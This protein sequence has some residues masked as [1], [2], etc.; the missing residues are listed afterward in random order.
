[1]LKVLY[2]IAL[3]S[4]SP[5]SITHLTF[6]L[7][8]GDEGSVDSVYFVFS[9]QQADKAASEVEGKVERSEY[10]DLCLKLESF[11]NCVPR[12]FVGPPMARYS[13]VLAK[14]HRFYG[15]IVTAVLSESVDDGVLE[16]VAELEEKDLTELSH[17]HEKRR[18][19][20]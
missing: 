2:C 19:L 3:R 17:Q 20:Q 15:Q 16:N 1:M 12:N 13:G 14:V 9:S 4:D 11:K 6:A 10:M 8:E 5:A 18:R 7:G